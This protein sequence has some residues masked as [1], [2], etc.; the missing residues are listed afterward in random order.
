MEDEDYNWTDP[1]FRGAASKYIAPQIYLETPNRKILEYTCYDRA[2]EKKLIF[3]ELSAMARLS[4]G[5]TPVIPGGS[6]KLN[7]EGK[8]VAKICM[9]FPE[10]K[11]LEI[12]K[13]GDTLIV[14]LP[15]ITVHN[16]FEIF[17][18]D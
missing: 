4:G 12:K 13:D 16:V 9:A 14:E 6:L 5:S 1:F 10:K 2:S 18:E 3:H 8:Q 15:D 17:Y 11:E 7:L